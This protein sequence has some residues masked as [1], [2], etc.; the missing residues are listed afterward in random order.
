MV[1]YS[2]VAHMGFVTLGLF[3]FKIQGI[4]GAVMQMI[5][6]GVVSAALFLCV[7]LIYDR[8]HTR[9]IKSYGGVVNVMPFYSFSFMIFMLASVGLPG[10]S[11]FV[12]EILVLISTFAINPWL[13]LLAGSS[14]ILGAAY[15]I[16]LYK[17]VVFGK[18]IHEKIKHLKDLTLRERCTL[19]PLIILV[20]V[21]GIFP[22]LILELTEKPIIE[23]ILPIKKAIVSINY[24]NEIGGIDAG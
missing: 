20:I 17:R 23:L 9:E 18:I 12:G 2:P 16:W 14:L 6:H 19:I 10:T 7:G 21:L 4:Q 13:A 22:N 5:S 1:T 3:T 11:G 24:Q 8:M 15:M